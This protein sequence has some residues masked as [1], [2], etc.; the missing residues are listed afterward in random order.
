[1]KYTMTT[2]QAIVYGA[3]HGFTEFLPISAAAH[4]IL[5]AYVT[6]W[7]EPSGAFL[8]ALSVGS[9]LAIIAYFI[10]DWLSMISSFLQIVIYR[11]K[12]MTL[13]ER[14]PLFLLLATLPIALVWHYFHDAIASRLDS[15]PLMVAA[16]LAG[17]GILLWAA[18][19][20]SRRNKNMYDWNVL[21]SIIVGVLEIAALI[22]GCG[23]SAATMTGGLFRNFTR[24][25]AAKFSFFC[26]APVLVA[27]AYSHL[28]GVAFGG[29]EPMPELSW[30]SFY[31]AMIVALLSS[32]LAI[33][34]F[35]KH[36]QRGGMA[37]YAIWRLLVA[38]G[39]GV[40]YWLRSD[41]GAGF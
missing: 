38:C 22:P 31:V 8:G 9:A 10:H 18:D 4:R 3:L 27:S 16:A 23:R 25:A 21:D 13:D 28:Q 33:G 34:A 11:K 5:L 2:F 19:H 29:S 39:I 35:M 17:F 30:L 6:G 40:L 32:L 15:S 14:M 24:E 26:A 12:P 36:V 37:Q 20:L 7:N 41:Q 1:M